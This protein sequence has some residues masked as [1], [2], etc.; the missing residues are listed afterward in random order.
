MCTPT[1]VTQ[2]V[3]APPEFH[4]GPIDYQMHLVNDANQAQVNTTIR[5]MTFS[6]VLPPTDGS[7]GTMSAVLDAR[8]IYPLFN[9]IPSPTPDA[10]CTALDSFDA[11]CEPCPQDGLPFCL[12]IGAIALEAVPAPGMTIA[13]L[14]AAGLGPECADVIP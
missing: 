3:V 5:S 13:P 2:A 11:P 4:L 6:N 14:D 7:E 8:E 10:V 1:L 12:T 9:L